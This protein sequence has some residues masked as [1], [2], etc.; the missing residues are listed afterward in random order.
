MV[1]LTDMEH[2]DSDG[3]TEVIM[4]DIANLNVVGIGTAAARQSE[5]ALRVTKLE[6]KV[7]K[8]IALDLPTR[9][10]DRDS[11]GSLQQIANKADRAPIG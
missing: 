10:T 2:H 5:R 8:I 7:E 3:N 1:L 11:A 4:G 6:V 9:L